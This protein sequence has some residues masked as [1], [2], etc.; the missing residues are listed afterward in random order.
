MTAQKIAEEKK[1]EK[2]KKRRKMSSSIMDRDEEWVKKRRG[3]EQEKLNT[4]Q[5]S[6]FFKIL[7][8]EKDLHKQGP[9]LEGNSESNMNGLKNPRRGKTASSI[10]N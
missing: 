5:R 3:N 2:Q 10:L 1:K 6:S 8:W 7:I 9:S 4:S